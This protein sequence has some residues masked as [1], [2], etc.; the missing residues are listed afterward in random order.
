MFVK[1]HM[2]QT[3]FTLFKAQQMTGV[4]S[5]MTYLTMPTNY[6]VHILLKEGKTESNRLKMN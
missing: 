6:I 3:A 5:V 2:I 1:Y 4:L